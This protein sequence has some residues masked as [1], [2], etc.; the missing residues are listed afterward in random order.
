[1]IVYFI[2]KKVSPLDDQETDGTELYGDDDCY[3]IKNISLQF[4]ISREKRAMEKMEGV[5]E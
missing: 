3:C 2:A 4:L 1:M 5:N